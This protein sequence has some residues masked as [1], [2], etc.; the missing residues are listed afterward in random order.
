M[1]PDSVVFGW[2]QLP[3]DGYAQYWIPLPLKMRPDIGFPVG[4]KGKHLGNEKLEV[5]DF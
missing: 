1:L 5:C 4:P 2:L 3:R